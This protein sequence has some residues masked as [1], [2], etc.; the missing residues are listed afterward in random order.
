MLPPLGIS[1]VVEVD[2]ALTVGHCVVLP[3]A[4]RRQARIVGKEGS[5]ADKP[6]HRRWRWAGWVRGE[7]ERWGGRDVP[8]VTEGGFIAHPLV[9]R[10]ARPGRA[11]APPPPPPPPSSYRCLVPLVL[12]VALSSLCRSCMVDFRLRPKK[13]R[14]R[15]ARRLKSS[16]A[17]WAAAGPGPVPWGCSAARSRWP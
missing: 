3:T 17:L 9:H 13:R 1:V 15:L 2:F 7:V 16:P 10:R 8:W 6:T 12:E 4:S 5:E 11:T 14:E